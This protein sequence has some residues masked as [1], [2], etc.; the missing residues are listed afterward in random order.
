MKTDTP[1]NTTGPKKRRHSRFDLTAVARFGEVRSDW[2][3]KA[4][5]ETMWSTKE[6]AIY[7]GIKPS[8]LRTLLSA[9]PDSP[10]PTVVLKNAAGAVWHLW[11]K[12]DR[13]KVALWWTTRPSYSKYQRKEEKR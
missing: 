11:N 1:A 13:D 9:D 4:P 3:M 10:Q 5:H 2:H 12:A 6:V 7:F 8:T